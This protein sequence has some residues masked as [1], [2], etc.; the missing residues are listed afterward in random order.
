VVATLCIAVREP[1]PEPKAIRELRQSLREA[2][3]DS[4]SLLITNCLHG[5]KVASYYWVIIAGLKTFIRGWNPPVEM[6]EGSSAVA[7]ILDKGELDEAQFMLLDMFDMKEISEPVPTGETPYPRVITWLRQRGT[8]HMWW[9]IYDPDFPI[10]VPMATESSNSPF[11]PGS[12]G[13]LATSTFGQQAVRAMSQAEML[14]A[15]GYHDYDT[16]RLRQHCGRSIDD[17]VRTMVS[18][19]AAC[20]V[21]HQIWEAFQ[22]H[23][24]TLSHRV[25]TASVRVIL[26]GIPRQSWPSQPPLPHIVIAQ[27]NVN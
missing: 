7:D 8:D 2:D 17:R 16:D 23:W 14:R 24:R 27:H 21:N 26:A 19:Q 13:I 10:P 20:K 11:G 1:A 22:Q 4:T 5:G 9:P 25:P 12:V 3:W 15:Y 6:D 18:V